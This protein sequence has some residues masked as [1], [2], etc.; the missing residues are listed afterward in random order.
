MYIRLLFGRHEGEVRDIAPEAAL[1]IL[2]DDRAADGFLAG[3]QFVSA[4]QE[5]LYR[6][7][8]ECWVI[9]ELA[10]LSLFTARLEQLGFTDIAVE[11]L[12]TCKCVW[13]LR[14]RTPLGSR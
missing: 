11:H 14:S 8:C 1:A 2:A 10:Q 3:T 13:R 7:L 6:K 12:Q 4:L 5:R 9:E